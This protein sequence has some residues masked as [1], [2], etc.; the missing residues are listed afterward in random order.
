MKQSVQASLE[1]FGNTVTIENTDGTSVTVKALLQPVTSK[2]VQSMRWEI[3]PGGEIPIGQ[4]LYIGPAE[5]QFNSVDYLSMSGGEYIVRRW[6]TIRVRDTDLF[7]WALC[8]KSGREDPWR[9]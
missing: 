3:Q 6:E 2:S 1:R 7:V 4:Y 5:Q 8:A 9:S